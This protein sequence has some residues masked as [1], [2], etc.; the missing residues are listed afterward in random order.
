MS[1]SSPRIRHEISDLLS[2]EQGFGTYIAIVTRKRPEKMRQFLAH[3]TLIVQETRMT[4]LTHI[5]CQ[6]VEGGNKVGWPHLNQSLYA[7]NFI[8]QGERKKG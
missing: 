8:N 2:W 6:Q 1:D 4:F 3:Q 7:V 5:I